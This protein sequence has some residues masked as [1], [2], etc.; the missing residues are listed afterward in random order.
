[1]KFI[2]RIL[3]LSIAIL[4]F[5]CSNDFELFTEREEIPVVYGLLSKSDDTHYIRL[6][7]AFLDEER[8]AF[9][10][11][12]EP[13]SIFY[14][15]AVVELIHLNSEER[16]TLERVNAAERDL[17]RVEGHFPMDP[18]YLYAIEQEEIEL[19]GSQEYRLEVSRNGEIIA[20]AEIPILNDLRLFAPNSGQQLFSGQISQNFR[21]NE[22]PLAYFY[23]FRLVFKYEERIIGG[24]G[25]G[26]FEPKEVIWPIATRIESNNASARPIDLIRFVGN[27][28][29]VNPNAQRHFSQIDL[30]LDAGGED[31]SNYIQVGFANTGITS[32]QE[33]PTYTNI[34]GGL[35][36]LSSMNSL[37]INGYPLS[38]Q[39]LDSLAESSATRDLNF[40]R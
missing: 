36:V 29:P 10:V 24:G 4:F 7:R 17:P 9:L 21:W 37:R 27:A 19:Q 38:G 11:A 31:I 33:V 2:N 25:N 26:E 5:S 14:D 34:D 18:N 39:A 12:S 20:S 30:I 22:L 6:E 1:M 40:S 3:L 23:N 8:S 28:I 15:D 13:D 16:F 35:G 32:S